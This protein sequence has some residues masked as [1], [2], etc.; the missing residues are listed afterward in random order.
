MNALSTDNAIRILVN[1]TEV[2]DAQHIL[3]GGDRG[4]HYGDG[5]FETMRLHEGKLQWFMDHLRRLELGCQRL[6]MTM[7]NKNAIETQLSML[8]QNVQ[9]GVVKLIVTR[10]ASGRGYRPAANSVPTCF[11]ALYPANANNAAPDAI[12]VRWCTTQLGRNPLL[13][14]IK[15]L[16]RLEQ[17]LAQAEWTDVAIAEGLLLDSE[18]ELV[19]CT[20]SN[21]FLVSD[22]V[23]YTPDLR[24]SGIRG[25]MRGQVLAAANALG[26]H[27]EECALRP[28][29][30]T[31]AS[32]VFVTNAVRGVR[33]VIALDELR[34]PIGA[35][36]RRIAKHLQLW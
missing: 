4:F 12:A 16:N 3:H 13:A 26:I 29:D 11:V 17:V 6:R 20:A 1:G 28:Q 24:Y 25:V 9:E 19:C 23:L 18:G 15:H 14:G 36:T 8:T 33:P 35:L 2:T 30:L 10:G 22:G 7:P 5:L 27:T 34:W 31:T 32:E 21:I